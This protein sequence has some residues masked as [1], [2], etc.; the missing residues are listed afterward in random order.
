MPGIISLSISMRFADISSPKTEKPVTVPPGLAKL[1]NSS[2]AVCSAGSAIATTGIFVTRAMAR[3]AAGP[4]ERNTS[5]GSAASSPIM[6]WPRAT[7]PSECRLSITML[8][9]MS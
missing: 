5:T 7:S 3:V 9:P 6:A 8:R 1:A 4:G 2:G